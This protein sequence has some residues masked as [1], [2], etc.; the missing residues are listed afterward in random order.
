MPNKNLKNQP[1]SGENIGISALF[2]VVEQKLFVLLRI[3]PL[4]RNAGGEACKQTIE[5]FYEP[6]TPYHQ[7]SAHHQC[8]DVPR[9]TGGRALWH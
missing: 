7:E 6:T 4:G 5:H 3:L 8:A 2:S 9:H 1:P